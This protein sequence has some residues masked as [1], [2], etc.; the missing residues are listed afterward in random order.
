M[1]SILQLI[2]ITAAGFIAA[3]VGLLWLVRWRRKL[4]ARDETDAR[5]C[6]RCGYNLTGLRVPRCPECGCVV[7][8]DRTFAEMGV[9]EKEVIEHVEQRD[10]KPTGRNG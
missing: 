1:E 9:D 5:R 8:F 4:L 3:G 7:G 6:A 10:D 2:A